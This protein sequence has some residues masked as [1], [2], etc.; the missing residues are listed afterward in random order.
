MKR[1]KRVGRGLFCAASVYCRRAGSHGRDDDRSLRR[2]LLRVFER[3]R[4]PDSSKRL[5]ALQY[6]RD[7]E[8]HRFIAGSITS[9]KVVYL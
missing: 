5:H 8:A 2:S 1:V 4:I 3:E 7:C 6:M 9:H